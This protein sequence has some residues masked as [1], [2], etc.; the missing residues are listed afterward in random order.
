MKLNVSFELMLLKNSDFV[1]PAAGFSHQQMG[2]MR[3]DGDAIEWAV[4]GSFSQPPSG[5]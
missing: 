1:C 4:G 5:S 3:E 2:G